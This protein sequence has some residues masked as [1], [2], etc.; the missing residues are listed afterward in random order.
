[1]KEKLS[2]PLKRTRKEF[3][4]SHNISYAYLAKMCLDFIQEKFGPSKAPPSLEKLSSITFSVAGQVTGSGRSARIT[5][6]NTGLTF[7]NQTI[8]KDFLSALQRE[9]NRRNKKIELQQTGETPWPALPNVKVEVMNDAKAALLGEVFYG[10]LQG[11]N[12]LKFIA[13][14]GGGSEAQLV[15]YTEGTNIH[16]DHHK[17]SSGKENAPAAPNMNEG[18]HRV[19]YDCIR[20]EYICYPNGELTPYIN[21]DGSFKK[22]PDHLIYAEH[23]IAGPWNAI[24]FIRSI[25][26]NDQAKIAVAKRIVKNPND[27]SEIM[28]ALKSLHK[29]GALNVQDRTEWAVNSDAALVRSINNI[30][31]NPRLILEKCQL[32]ARRS[33]G[34]PTEDDTLVEMAYNHF[35]KY[36]TEL[37]RILGATYRTTKEYGYPLDKII[38]GG[39][40]G[41]H[42][43]TF[44]KYIRKMVIEHMHRA[45]DIPAGVINFSVLTPEARECAANRADVISKEE[46]DAAVHH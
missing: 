7:K 14:T 26:E 18:G 33:S 41:E 22:L 28:P 46:A 13:G 43:N 38:V 31:L 4:E 24:R 39:G 17:K 6:T 1:M 30:V 37:G 40:I 15:R 2:G 34:H 20:G 10:K 29:L 32:D 23:I 42:C 21:P 45:G 8:A 44:P 11:K 9:I 19:I 12:V 36:F 27:P 3:H 25:L 5:T 35:W 16:A